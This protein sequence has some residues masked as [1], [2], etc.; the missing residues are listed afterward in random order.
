[1]YDIFKLSMHSPQIFTRLFNFP[2]PVLEGRKRVFVSERIH[3]RGIDLSSSRNAIMK[4]KSGLS[5]ATFYWLPIYTQ[6]PNILYCLLRLSIH[7]HHHGEIILNAIKNLFN[8]SPYFY[9]NKTVG[10]STA[11][12]GV[13]KMQSKVIHI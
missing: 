5:K 9:G 10:S 2:S 12:E 1:M 6:T 7:R 11:A 3:W 8:N 13:Q 4:M